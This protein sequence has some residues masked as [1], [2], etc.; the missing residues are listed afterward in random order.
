MPPSGFEPIKRVRGEKTQQLQLQLAGGLDILLDAARN[1][2][3]NSNINQAAAI[4]FFALLAII[5][6]FILTIILVNYFFGSFPGT[7]ELLFEAISEY[8]PYISE[9]LFDQLGKIEEKKR[10]LGWLGLLGLLW[11]AAMAIRSLERSLKMIFRVEATRNFLTSTALALGI[12]TFLWVVALLMIAANYTQ[13]LFN[14]DHP[15]REMI[16]GRAPSNVLILFGYALPKLISILIV[17]SCYKFIPQSRI[18]WTSALAG[19]V[20]FT[21]FLAMAKLAFSWYLGTH[22]RYSIIYGSLDALV[23]VIIWIFYLSV[24]FLFAAE[25][26]S[27]YGRRDTILLER[28]LLGQNVKKLRVADR[29][30]RKFGQTYQPGAY[31]FREGEGGQEMYYILQG[32]VQMEKRSGD[33][34]RVLAQMGPGDYFGE[35]ALLVDTRRTAS[36]QVLETS[37]IATIQPETFRA[38]LRENEEVAILMLREFSQRLK[39]AGILLDELNQS[40]SRL[41]VLAYLMLQEERLPEGIKELSSHL[42]GI[43][44]KD[45]AE[46]ED[47]MGSLERQGLLNSEQGKITGLNKAKVGEF[48]RKGQG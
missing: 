1:F 38:I 29:I 34:T 22:A 9:K 11:V 19:G 20:I 7:Q 4:A 27:S 28:V 14:L 26:V 32:R 5:P 10:L 36:V 16:L 33:V 45:A 23:I 41:M 2:R 37:L 47:L 40:W 30:Y 43:T 48:W 42:A 15:V 17:G 13:E 21:F 18:T 12:M 25:L 8:H 44:G 3:Q 39:N 6:L 31:I 24:I 35:M 46:V